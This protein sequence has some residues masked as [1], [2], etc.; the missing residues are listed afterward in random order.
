MCLED[1]YLKVLEAQRKNF[2]AQFSSLEEMGFKDMLKLTLKNKTDNAL[3]EVSE[4]PSEFEGFSDSDGTE[5]LL[6]KQE[7][8]LA[9][10]TIVNKSEETAPKVVKLIE[11][12]TVKPLMSKAEQKILKLGRA[13][14]LTEMLRKQREVMKLTKKQQEQA[15]K[16]DDD[17]LENDL[18]LQRL[19]EESHI[20]A[21]KVEYSG[22]DLT[23][24]TIDIEEP[25]GKARKRAL[26]S[27]IR[28]IAATN[29]KTGGL[30]KTLESMPMTMR[31]GMIDSKRKK[32]ERYE[33]EAR[34][35][36]IVLS[37]IKKGQI[38]NINA[39][40]GSTMDSDRL[41]TVSNKAKRI[42]NRGLKINTVG[43]STKRGLVISQK[44]IDKINGTFKK[45]KNRKRR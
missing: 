7:N 40:K 38:R 35:A 26:D 20:L 3:D 23:L 39:G 12:S 2:E 13:P 45:E 41:G 28:K 1:D 36:G 34:N 42:R 31:K 27:R 8:H 25:T 37:K 21:N 18:K 33:N 22:A 9:E 19:L 4:S 5:N 29:S 44:E 11:D 43:K 30:P 16:E 10:H 15:N 14:T 32:A 24:K 6:K 17:N